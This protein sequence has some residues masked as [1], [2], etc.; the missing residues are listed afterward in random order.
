MQFEE[1]GLGLFISSEILKRHKGSFWIESEVGKGST[2]S[3][4]CPYQA[5][6]LHYP[7]G[8]PKHFLKKI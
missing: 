2:F 3:S 5:T 4:V 6:S 8:V 7:K 1:L